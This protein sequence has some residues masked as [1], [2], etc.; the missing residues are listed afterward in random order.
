MIQFRDKD[1]ALVEFLQLPQGQLSYSMHGQ[2]Q[3]SNAMLEHEGNCILIYD[4]DVPESPARR[5]HPMASQL[6]DM[7]LNFMKIAN[8][9]QMS[10]GVPGEARLFRAVCRWLELRRIRYEASLEWG[11]H[12]TIGPEQHGKPGVL[13]A[14]HL[15]S[16]DLHPDALPSLK[17]VRDRLVYRGG[18]V[19][20]DCKSGVVII[21][22]AVEQL[23]AS[24]G[25]HWVHILLTVGEESGQKGAIRAPLPRLIGYR[26]RY[27]IVVDRMTC[28]RNAPVTGNKTVRHVINEYKDVPLLDQHCGDDMLRHLTAAGT[29]LPAVASPNCA[30]AL[31]LRGRWDAEVTAPLLLQRAGAPQRDR[32]L[33]SALAAYKFRTSKILE[34][35]RT[36]PPEQRVCGMNQSPRID[37]YRAMRQ[38]HDCVKPYNLS[39]NLWFSC[40]NLSCWSSLL[41]K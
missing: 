9:Q 22:R 25:N 38:V 39:R 2:V 4:R 37:R 5:V 12:A 29:D 21:L 7:A 36:V 32:A 17:V 35:M 14:A 16:D 31:E 23:K 1:G 15:D 11:I 3:I 34:A 27:A 24:P 19:G 18:S 10:G 13:L 41:L 20:L 28:G 6:P 40:V 26:V 33:A 30:D 8:P